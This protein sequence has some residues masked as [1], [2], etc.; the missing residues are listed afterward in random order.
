MGYFDAAIAKQNEELAHHGIIGQ[1]W[2]V[3]RFQNYDGTRIKSGGSAS[4]KG[5]STAKT[6]TKKT[7]HEFKD[8]SES[9]SMR[10]DYVKTLLGMYGATAIGGLGNAALFGMGY[11]SPTL[12]M[13]TAA[14]AIAS[15]GYTAGLIAGD[16][17]DAKANAKEKKFAEERAQNP[18]DKSTGFHKKTTEMTPKEDME[19]VNPAY[20][21]WDENTKNNCALCTMSFELRRRG[22]DVQAKKATDGYDADTLAG[23]WFT[24][25]KS[26]PTSGSMTDADILKQYNSGFPPYIDRKQ[27]KEM[28]SD[29]LNQI[30][31]QKD[32]ARGQ[33]TIVWDGT[34][35]GHSVA[36]ANEGGQPAIYDTQANESYIGDKAV[37]RYL[38]KTSQVNVTR[39]DNCKINKKYIKEVAE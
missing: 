14:T 9:K 23:D 33:L 11:I 10:K 26:K 32:G 21:N 17:K 18:V 25:A 1:K 36:Y 30:K 37:T 20:K 3:R 7:K 13:T 27:Q 39:L 34:A 2:G 5:K 15:V 4:G 8:N 16:V 38:E 6:T 31:S 24:G 22:Y 28:I 29:T 35:A 12:M 19:R